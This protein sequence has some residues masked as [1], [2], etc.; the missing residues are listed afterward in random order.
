MS[1]V[2]KQRIAGAISVFGAVG[3]LFCISRMIPY[4]L[5]GDTG[6]VKLWFVLAIGALII[7]LP[8]AVAYYYYRAKASS[9]ADIEN[10][11]IVMNILSRTGQK[12]AEPKSA[13]LELNPKDKNS[14]N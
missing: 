7:S 8:F 4:G 6:K 11:R 10:Q 5:G 9:G 13:F 14:K 3:I 2:A 1:S 12:S